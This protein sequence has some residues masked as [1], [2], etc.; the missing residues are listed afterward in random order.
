MQTKFLKNIVETIAGKPATE[1]VD[2]LIGKKDV[3]EFLIAKKLKL[4]INQTR[5]ILYKLS[6]NGI[7]S[8]TRK[9]D[10]RKGWYIYFWTLNNLKCLELLEKKLSE[11]VMRLENQLKSRKTKRFYFCETCNVEIGEET[12]L[13]NQFTCSECGEVYKLME[14]DKVIKELGNRTEKLH[15]NIEAIRKEKEKELE[16]KTK[17]I[18]RKAAREK[19]KKKPKKKKPKKKIKKKAKKPKKKLKKE[20]KKPK[21]KKSKKQKPKKQKK[22]IK[23]PKKKKKKAKKKIKIKKKKR[24][25]RGKRK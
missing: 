8:F 2:L 16:K 5:N 23:K 12:A 21:K 15:K 11:E 10:K 17:E 4:T 19:I 9:K 18:R 13:L 22:K 3:N 6:D 14:S 7:V 1:I 20:K 24:K 25:Q